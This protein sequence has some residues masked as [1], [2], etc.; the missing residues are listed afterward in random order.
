MRPILAL[1]ATLGLASA[2]GCVNQSDAAESR[3]PDIV[4][5]AMQQAQQPA[6]AAGQPTLIQHPEHI[7]PGISLRGGFTQLE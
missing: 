4:R 1:C 7:Q 3:E 2:I 5:R 6:S